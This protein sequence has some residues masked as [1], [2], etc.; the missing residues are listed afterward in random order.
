MSSRSRVHKPFKRREVEPKPEAV[1]RGS[2]P[3]DSVINRMMYQN[4]TP[5]N[6][7][8]GRRRRQRGYKRAFAKR[9]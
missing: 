5:A 4:G 3:L 6:I 9:P 1:E 7:A 2:T 8:A